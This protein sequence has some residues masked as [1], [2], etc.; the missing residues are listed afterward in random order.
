MKRPLGRVALHRELAQELLDEGG[1]L[2]IRHPWAHT[3]EHC[4]EIQLPFL[5]TVLPDTPIVPLL[6]GRQDMETCRALAS[7][8]SGLIKDR[9]ILLLATTDLS[10]Y[11]TGNQARVLD[12]N[13]VHRVREYQPEVLHQDMVEGKAEA[14]GG[15]ALVAVMLALQE[16][17]RPRSHILK[18]ANSG[19]ASGDYSRVV[20][21]MS[22]AFTI[23][24]GI[25]E[26]KHLEF[27]G[28]LTYLSHWLWPPAEAASETPGPELSERDRKFLLHL[29]RDVLECAV[30]R[31][32][33]KWPTD[34]PASLDINRGVFV[35]LKKNGRLRG[36]IGRIDPDK[37]LYRLVPE[38][39][40]Q[41]AYYDHRFPPLASKEL[42]EINIEISVLT[43]LEPVK[44]VGDIVIGR[45]GLLIVNGNHSGLLL[46]Q[47]PL[48]QG[49]D[50]ARFLSGLCRKAGLPADA[51]RDKQTRLFHFGA[52]VFGEDHPQ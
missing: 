52:Q 49:W 33:F 19:D 48:E 25:G 8:L 47:V 27:G 26:F 14:C 18:Y 24:S 28:I 11:Y 1:G 7:I 15:G 39:A 13:L 31:R 37:P 29:A 35:T 40:I 20:G 22:A 30:D 44:D 32:D 45:H 2:I 46:P 10:H 50:R 23:P 4:L 9:K 43:A 42:K 51:W 5:Q 3:D 16:A 34:N 41:S 21:Y 6:M 36:C 38:M 12:M 17:Y